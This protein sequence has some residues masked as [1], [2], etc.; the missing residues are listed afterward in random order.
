MLSHCCALLRRAALSP[1]ASVPCLPPLRAAAAAAPAPRMLSLLPQRTAAMPV[2]FA[3]SLCSGPSEASKATV[4]EFLRVASRPIQGK[5]KAKTSAGQKA[6]DLTKS[7]S[8]LED[9]DL[10]GVL[11][12]D[13]KELKR[14][15]LGVQERKRLLKYTHK[16]LQGWRHDGRP[17]KRAWKGWAAPYR[18]PD[19]PSSQPGKQPYILDPETYGPGPAGW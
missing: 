18:L 5:A 15:G 1:R 16:Y 12:C 13:G 2:P 7:A 9:L 4:T 10:G 8:K 14:R 3:R 17:G 6:L 11:R 19:H